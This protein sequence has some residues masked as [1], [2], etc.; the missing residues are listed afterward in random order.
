MTWLNLVL[1]IVR[2]ATKLM[3]WSE[4]DHWINEG[5]RRAAA[6]NLA[7]TTKAL[8]L[9]AGIQKEWGALT[10]EEVDKRIEAQGWFRD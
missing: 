5:E 2:L 3:E 1:A 8:A 9:A 7:A 4:Q 6:A 10:D